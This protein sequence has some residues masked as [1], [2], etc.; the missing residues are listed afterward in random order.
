MPMLGCS[1]SRNRNE[2]DVWGINP[3][4]IRNSVVFP[5]PD[6]PSTQTNS[7][8]CISKEISSKARNPPLLS[9]NTAL[10]LRMVRMGDITIYDFRLMFYEYRFPNN[11]LRNEVIRI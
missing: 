11:E 7:R 1:P 9:G 8:A 5:E 6:G 4:R 3:A 10:K 2:P